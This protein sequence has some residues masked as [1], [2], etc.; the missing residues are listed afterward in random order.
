[1]K[2]RNGRNRIKRAA[3]YLHACAGLLTRSDQ[4]F[5]APVSCFIEPT[6]HCNLRCPLC[7]AGSGELRRPRGSMSIHQ[8]EHIT[9][10]LPS[11]ITDLY[12]WGQGEPFI[13]PD[14]LSMVQLASGLGFRTIVSTNGHF[15]D[16]PEDIIASGLHTLI[17][18]LD[19]VDRETY[20]S[21]R[22]GGSFNKVLE[23]IHG[24][25]DAAAREKSGPEV[26]L[27]C[28]VTS[29]NEKN[30]AQFKTLARSLGVNRTV[31]KTLQISSLS[32]GESSYSYLPGDPNLSRYRKIKSGN[33]VRLETDRRRVLRDRCLRLYYSLQVDWEGNV[34]PCCFDKNSEYIM[35][36]LL[37][38]SFETIW[39]GERFRS[40]RDGLNRRGRVLP[41]C[42]N[43]TE[44][45]R[46]MNIHA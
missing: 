9:G 42:R 28:V 20:E 6:N 4:T 1:M 12:L 34:V 33:D 45:L 7:A 22:I 35:G 14:F 3:G 38:E 13:A 21:Y 43:C 17:V 44:G 26:E 31:F 37:S 11:G 10:N 39:N 41:M 40:F 5:G 46:R 18:S 27:Q 19:G 36:N 8:F 25:T 24:V 23:G 15:L 30:L 32:G 29:R 16:T 2:P